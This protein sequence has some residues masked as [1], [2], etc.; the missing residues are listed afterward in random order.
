VRGKAVHDPQTGGLG[1]LQACEGQPAT[2]ATRSP[3]LS[4]SR[5]RSNSDCIRGL[6]NGRGLSVPTS[7][8]KDAANA[9]G[10]WHLQVVSSTVMVAQPPVQQQVS[11]GRLVIAAHAPGTVG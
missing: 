7:R 6:G 4:A 10:L 11:A 9:G 3:T 2:S 1:S 5:S 8:L